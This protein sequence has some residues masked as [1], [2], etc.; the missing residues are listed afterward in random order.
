MYKMKYL[1]DRGGK[2]IE[3]EQIITA[4]SMTE[5]EIDWPDFLTERCRTGCDENYNYQFHHKLN[6]KGKTERVKMNTRGRESDRCKV[7]N[8]KKARS[9]DILFLYFSWINIDIVLRSSKKTTVFGISVMC[10]VITNIII[11]YY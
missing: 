5:E 3:N 8:A 10:L 7:L 11:N 2:E 1:I 9:L 6:S 4:N